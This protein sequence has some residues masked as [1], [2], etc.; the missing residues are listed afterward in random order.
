MN[1]LLMLTDQRK[2]KGHFKMKKWILPDSKTIPFILRTKG[3][4]QENKK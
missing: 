1:L 3:M 2:L 4:I